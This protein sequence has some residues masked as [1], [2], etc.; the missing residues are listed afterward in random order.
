MKAPTGYY[1]KWLGQFEGVRL[2]LTAYPMAGVIRRED[3]IE[4]IIK[5]IPDNDEYSA[6]YIDSLRS[7][8]MV[9]I[10]ETHLDKHYASGELFFTT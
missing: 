2:A 5:V 7:G 10:V 1:R 9:P 6:Y 8:A 4:P 3:L